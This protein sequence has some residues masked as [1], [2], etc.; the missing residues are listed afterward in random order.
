MP[1]ISTGHPLLLL[2]R[3]RVV[4]PLAG[5]PGSTPLVSNPRQFCCSAVSAAEQVGKHDEGV[6]GW[7]ASCGSGGI[8]GGGVGTNVGVE[9]HAESPAISSASSSVGRDTDSGLLR[10]MCDPLDGGFPPL[11]FDGCGL[12]CAGGHG[13]NL[14]AFVL[15]LRLSPVG[16]DL[17][18]VRDKH[19]AG[20]SNGHRGGDVAPV[21][22][23]QERKRVHGRKTRLPERGGLT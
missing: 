7:R 8:D 4:G 22:Q 14:G 15:Q 10:V 3:Q 18:F 23:G 5:N 11:R 12:G 9:L 2:R 13:G 21:T 20:A 17:A 1:E 6:A 19:C 16:A